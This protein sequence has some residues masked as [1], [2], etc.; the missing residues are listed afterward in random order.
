M[1][2]QYE[3]RWGYFDYAEFACKCGCGKN[4]TD[5]VFVDMLDN[6]RAF[7]GTPFIINSGY[8]CPLHNQAVGSHANNHPSGQAADIRCTEGPA[9]MKIV[10]AL[11]R[12]GFR[13]IG[14]HNKF[15]HADRMDQSHDKVQSFWPY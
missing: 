9:R 12:A 13:R 10:E 7:S 2:D 3:N 11:I 14:F 6:A 8:R 15:I 4:E 1:D 5:P